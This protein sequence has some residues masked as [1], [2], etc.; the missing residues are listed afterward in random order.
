MINLCLVTPFWVINCVLLFNFSPPPCPWLL[1]FVFILFY[2]YFHFFFFFLPFGLSDAVV[3]SWD[4]FDWCC[5]RDGLFF[6][7][8]CCI[9]LCREENIGRFPSFLWSHSSYLINHRSVTQS[10]IKEF[11]SVFF[12]LIFIYWSFVCF[13]FSLL[14][15]F[16]G[17]QT[18]QGELS[19]AFYHRVKKSNCCIQASC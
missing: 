17:G 8:L 3:V 10:K 19:L 2:G 5:T 16:C 14:L 1:D 18:G 11:Y 4:G 9:L 15:F 6:V 13:F 7:C 12:S